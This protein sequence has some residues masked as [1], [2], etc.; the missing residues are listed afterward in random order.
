MIERIVITNQDGSVGVEIPTGAISMA[1]LMAR[2][3]ARETTVSAREITTEELPQDRLFRDA[4]DDSNPEDFI[5]TDLVKAQA[6]SHVMRKA[7]RD[8]K[9]IPLDKEAGFLSTT[10][11]RKTA[12]KNE[13]QAIDHTSS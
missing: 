4:W 11:G 12:I 7:D 9:M 5:G 6:I 3:N 8:T 13:K 2:V 1:E 10:T